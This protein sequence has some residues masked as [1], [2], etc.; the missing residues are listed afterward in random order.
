LLKLL[1]KMKNKAVLLI[2]GKFISIPFN[3][4]KLKG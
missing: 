4:F 1:I 2:K 3:E